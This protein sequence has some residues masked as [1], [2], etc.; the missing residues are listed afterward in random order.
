MATTRETASSPGVFEYARARLRYAEP[1]E[2]PR[3]MV[4]FARQG[5]QR[6]VWDRLEQRVYVI[7]DEEV[8]RV[9][10]AHGFRRDCWA[11]LECYQRSGFH[12][13]VSKEEFLRTAAERLRN[14]HH[15][16]TLVEDGTLLHY[17]WLGDRQTRA[18]DHKVGLVFLPPSGS[19]VVWDN[20][21]HPRGR[22]RGLMQQ[23]LRQSLHDAVTLA[24]ARRIYGYVF[25]HNL[26]SARSC[27]KIGLRH[28]GSLVREVRFGRIR[29]YAVAHE[30][31]FEVVPL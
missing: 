23:M 26:P 5:I 31:P 9:P 30:Q 19:A 4:R 24:G 11:D 20:Y 14:G 7:T 18:P 16:Y 2:I 17:G 10:R 6:R 15:S 25:S 21:S 8:S 27:E 1:R 3:L 13:Q 28:A 22:G 12:D 29:R